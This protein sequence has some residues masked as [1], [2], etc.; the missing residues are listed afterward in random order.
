MSIVVC[1]KLAINCIN[2]VRINL[3]TVYPNHK[4]P[5]KHPPP[6][7]NPQPTDLLHIR[8]TTNP[9]NRKQLTPANMPRNARPTQHLPIP[10]PLNIIFLVGDNHPVPVFQLEGEPLQ[11]VVRV[12]GALGMDAQAVFVVVFVG[13]GG[14]VEG[15]DAD[16]E[17]A[18]GRVEDLDLEGLLVEEG[19]CAENGVVFV[20][21]WLHG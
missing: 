16:C 19:G 6:S 18:V 10:L 7:Q 15:G 4:T 11:F 13:G 2:E 20:G 14:E 17:G 12:K 9:T 3:S 8:I 1:A 21:A 5:Q